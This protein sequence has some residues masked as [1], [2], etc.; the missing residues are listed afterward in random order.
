MDWDLSRRDLRIQFLQPIFE[1][2]NAHTGNVELEPQGASYAARNAM[3]SLADIGAAAPEKKMYD[4]VQAVLGGATPAQVD[5]MLTSA[6]SVPSGT[7]QDWA[8]L[9]EDQ[10]QLPPEAWDVLA[11]EDGLTPGDFGPYRFVS[12]YLNNEM[13]G[14][15]PEGN[16]VPGWA[17]GDSF[18]V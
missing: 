2:V 17:Q 13:Y 10:N 5:A 7:W 18:Q 3:L 16:R 1:I 8:D 4:L 6:T 12:A 14:E 11:Q 15:G 9:V